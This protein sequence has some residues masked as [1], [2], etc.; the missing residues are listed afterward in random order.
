MRIT[1]HVVNKIE[2]VIEKGT[3]AHVESD[4]IRAG[5]VKENNT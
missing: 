4:N 1:V 2:G 3:S 5:V